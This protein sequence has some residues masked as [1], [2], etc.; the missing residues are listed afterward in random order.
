MKK[1]FCILSII[2]MLSVFAYSNELHELLKYSSG[3]S[4]GT[5][6][7]AEKLLKKNPACINEVDSEGFR[8]IFYANSVPVLDLLIKYGGNMND[9]GPDNST[10]MQLLIKDSA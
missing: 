8:P 9:V 10:V 3:D 5:L 4:K 2:M 6:S 7:K 1:I